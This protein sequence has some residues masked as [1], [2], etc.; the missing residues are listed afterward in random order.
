MMEFT[1]IPHSLRQGAPPRLDVH[2]RAIETPEE[3]DR[4]ACELKKIL[5]RRED[6]EDRPL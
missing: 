1:V 3:I 5:R 6:D 4:L 2:A